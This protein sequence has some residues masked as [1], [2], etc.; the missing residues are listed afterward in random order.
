[1]GILLSSLA[2]AIVSAAAPQ[3]ALKVPKDSIQISVTGCV[4]DRLLTATR[5]PLIVGS[6]EQEDPEELDVPVDRFQI[7]GKKAIRDRVKEQDGKQ[8]R[9]VGLVRKG[10]LKEPGLRVPGGR[11]VISP[12]RGGSRYGPPPTPGARVILLQASSVEAVDAPCPR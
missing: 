2:L 10:D 9:I 12:G 3:D 11:V 1:M 7:A 8:V 5:I 6:D 4:K